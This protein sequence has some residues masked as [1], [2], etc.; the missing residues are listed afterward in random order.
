MMLSGWGLV[1]R[2]AGKAKRMLDIL[3]RTFD[4]RDLKYLEYAVK[5]FNSHLQVDIDNI[6]RVQRR[7]TR[8]PIEKLDYRKRLKIF[9][10]SQISKFTF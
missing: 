5:A 10:E 2:M 8:I 1:D 7:I 4:S 6:E 3:E 9:F